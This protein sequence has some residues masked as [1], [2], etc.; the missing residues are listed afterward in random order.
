MAEHRDEAAFREILAQLH[1][2][3]FKKSPLR[4]A[5]EREVHDRARAGSAARRRP[6]RWCGSMSTT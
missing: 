5:Y 6:R 4:L 3:G 1:E 2:T